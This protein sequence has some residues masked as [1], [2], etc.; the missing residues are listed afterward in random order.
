MLPRCR[1]Q[2]VY[3]FKLSVPLC[4]RLLC[5]PQIKLVGLAVAGFFSP[6]LTSLCGMRLCQDQKVLGTITT[7]SFC[8]QFLSVYKREGD[9]EENKT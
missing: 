2:L 4:P 6:L 1:A 9:R 5:P 7:I 8:S 3:M